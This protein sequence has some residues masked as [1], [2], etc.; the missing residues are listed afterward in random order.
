MGRTL[1]PLRLTNQPSLVEIV[2]SHDLKVTGR[3]GPEPSKG[4]LIHLE[5]QS[6]SDQERRKEE[7]PN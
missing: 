7:K 1:F 6:S 3:R 2:L 4:S 5:R